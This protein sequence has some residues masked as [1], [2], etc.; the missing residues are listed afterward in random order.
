MDANNKHALAVIKQTRAA[1]MDVNEIGLMSGNDEADE[2]LLS[3]IEGNERD[4][5]VNHYDVANENGVISNLLNGNDDERKSNDVLMIVD[6]A[7]NEVGATGNLL[8][9]TNAS[10]ESND[11]SMVVEAGANADADAEAVVE[12]DADADANT[13]NDEKASVTC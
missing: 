11:S 4:S 7:A 13:T 1:S 3:E 10:G 2:D 6:D 9:G 5:L 8:K 12:A